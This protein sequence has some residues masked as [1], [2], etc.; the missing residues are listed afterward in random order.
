MSPSETCA[1]A[2]LPP[3]L[4]DVIASRKGQAES[5]DIDGFYQRVASR[6]G[7][8][9]TAG[10]AREHAMAVMSTVVDQ[11]TEGE[12]DDLASQLPPGYAE[13]LR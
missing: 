6:E 12:R 2:Q 9:C 11:V 4:K 10:A 5:F 13:L 1:G 3:E 8:N 7:R